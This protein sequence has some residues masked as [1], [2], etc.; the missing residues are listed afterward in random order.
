MKITLPNGVTLDGT[1]DQILDVAEKLGF[2]DVLKGYYLSASKGWLEISKMNT[3]HL[4]NAI[5]KQYEEWVDDLHIITDPKVMV[6]MLMNGIE[7]ETW[8]DMVK[9]YSTRK[10]E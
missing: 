3:T 8:L 2:K 10:E 6:R 1:A 5:I 4:R 7:D 9:E